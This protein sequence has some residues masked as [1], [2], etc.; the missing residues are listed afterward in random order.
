MRA[1]VTVTDSR[2]EWFID[3]RRKWLTDSHIEWVIVTDDRKKNPLLQRWEAQPRPQGPPRCPTNDSFVGSFSRGGP[4]G[5]GCER[6]ARR[7]P[8]SVV[9]VLSDIFIWFYRS[10]TVYNHNREIRLIAE[11]G[12]QIVYSLP[13]TNSAKDQKLFWWIPLETPWR[14]HLGRYPLPVNPVTWRESVFCFRCFID[15]G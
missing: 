11:R 1:C 8:W 6:L 12:D 7:R 15:W 3:R 10:P 14:R 5:R 13:W 4:W 2:I 9:T